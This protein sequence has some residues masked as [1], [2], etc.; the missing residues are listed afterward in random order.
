MGTTTRRVA[1]VGLLVGYLGLFAAILVARSAPAT[2]YELSVYAAT[3]TATWIGLGVAAAAG[4]CV[5]FATTPADRFHGGAP[6]LVGATGVV[7]SAMPT[8][9]GYRYYGAGDGLTHLGW[10]REM[11]A[12]AISPTEVL[13]PGIHS[14]A[15][16]FSAVMGVPLTRSMQY[17]VLLA[18]PL[19][20][21]LTVPLAVRVVTD[22]RR[23]YA[24]AVA[25]AALFVPIN[26]ISVHPTAHPTSQAILLVPAAAYLALSYV[27]D[28]AADALEATTNADAGDADASAEASTD[29]DADDPSTPRTVT[30]GGGSVGV[31]GVGVLL[32]LVSAAFVLV[33]P[34]QALNLALVFLAVALL[35]A[36]LRRRDADS[37]IASHRWLGVQTGVLVGF[38]LLW[39]PRF[40]RARDTVAFTLGSIL[41]G[42][43]SAGTVVAAKAT[44]LTALGGSL[45]SLFFRLFVAGTAL[46]VV[47]G[48]LV[49]ATLAGR[50]ADDRTDAAVRYLATALVPLAGVFLVVFAIGAGDMYFRYQG[51]M[52]AFVTVLGA[53][54]LALAADRIDR[55]L[56]TGAGPAVVL[57]VLLV[58]APIAAVG[59]HASPFM[60]QPTPH[61]T[62]S[63][64][65]GH[66]AAFEHR[67]PGVPFTGLRGGPRRYVDAYYGTEFA[68][69]DLEFPGYDSGINDT[70]FT[71]ARYAGEFDETRYVAITESSRQRETALYDGFRYPE[72]G[73]RELETTPTVNRVQ[74]S[75]G[76]RVYYVRATNATVTDDA[77][78]DLDGDRVGVAAGDTEAD[79][80]GE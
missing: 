35:Q 63:Q 72:R 17:V 44:S 57:A 45:P 12:G 11:A 78:T 55:S 13:Y 79:T 39:T 16:A 53:A 23:A 65:D 24:V 77:A 37:S 48:G 70:T 76:L 15:V 10:A 67:E 71:G 6:L 4:L 8:L 49:L 2:G 60:Y 5:A 41:G 64:L 80:A 33:H 32:A 14:T 34:Q 38:F 74:S 59:Y 68:R 40:E 69:G 22:A 7:V 36:A 75:D 42:D 73:F 29:P 26:N 54:G 18:F 58:L 62:G 50:V 43:A 25:A 47:A 21:L 9:R 19:V 1:G 3:P 51:F 52:M 66:A 46:S 27:L 28:P 61:V 30:D 56:P 31:T 20:F